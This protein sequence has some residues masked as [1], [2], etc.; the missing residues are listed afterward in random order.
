MGSPPS[1]A[2]RCLTSSVASTALSSL[3]RRSMIARGVPAG[4]SNTDL[5]TTSKPGTP[6][7]A[8]VGDLRQKARALQAADAE[9]AQHSR[10]DVAMRG[11][12]RRKHHGDG[13]AEEII[14][15]RTPALGGGGG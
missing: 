9:R 1:R 11:G 5:C 4:A 10:R 13:T 7:S 8:M 15:G 14:G 12:D 6:A 2:S 3:L